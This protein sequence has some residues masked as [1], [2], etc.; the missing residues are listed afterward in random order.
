MGQQRRGDSL[1]HQR[2]GDSLSQQRRGD[3]LSHQRTRA[4]L[5]SRALFAVVRDVEGGGDA[6]AARIAYA[7]R[8]QHADGEAGCVEE[9]VG[10]LAAV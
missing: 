8:A 2:R 10:G 4:S 9:D 1:S 7:Q 5:A 3:S 6:A